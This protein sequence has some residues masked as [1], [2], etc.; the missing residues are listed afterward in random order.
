MRQRLDAR[1]HQLL[2]PAAGG[3]SAAQT[4]LDECNARGERL[5]LLGTNL[6]V[7]ERADEAPTDPKK[8]TPEDL[9]RLGLTHVLLDA[10]RWKATHTS[11]MAEQSARFVTYARWALGLPSDGSDDEAYLAKNHREG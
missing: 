2:N 1:L 6:A 5:T 9:M 3:L 4:Y 8:P 10:R 7:F 11:P